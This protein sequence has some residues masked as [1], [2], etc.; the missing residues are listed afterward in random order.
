MMWFY[1]NYPFPCRNG[2][3]RGGSALLQGNT[4]R[5][6]VNEDGDNKKCPYLR[7]ATRDRP[8]LVIY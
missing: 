7:A 3:G 6:Q 8:Y 2:V 4:Q 5:M 1:L